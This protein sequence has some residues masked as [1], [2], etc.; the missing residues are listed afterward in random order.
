[1]WQSERSKDQ[2]YDP[3][4]GEIAARLILNLSISLFLISG[5]VSVWNFTGIE[6]L[7]AF[8]PRGISAPRQTIY[9]LSLGSPA[10]VWLPSCSMQ[11]RGLLLHRSPSAPPLTTKPGSSGA[12]E[13]LTALTCYR[14]FF[15]HLISPWCSTWAPAPSSWRGSG[16]PTIV[17][18][19]PAILSL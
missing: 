12:R 18:R 11:C 5:S 3:L 15:V 7:F 17:G 16:T 14:P 6:A 2:D 13:L 10:F 8:R 19:I 4:H 9:A 1:M